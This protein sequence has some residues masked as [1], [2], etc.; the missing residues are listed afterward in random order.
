MSLPRPSFFSTAL[1]ECDTRQRETTSPLVVV[2]MSATVLT[3][4]KL[5][6][7][8]DIGKLCLPA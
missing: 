8:S 4:A 6:R 7:V 1:Q 2:L 5:I 3:M